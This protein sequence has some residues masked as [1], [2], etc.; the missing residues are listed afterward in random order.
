MREILVYGTTLSR[1][2]EINRCSRVRPSGELI[3]GV[4]GGGCVN[5]LVGPH[6]DRLKS[7]LRGH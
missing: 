4:K 3:A 6:N 5:F 2:T 1:R 7:V